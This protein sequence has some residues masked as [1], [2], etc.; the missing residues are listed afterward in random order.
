[1]TP[2][3]RL[4]PFVGAGKLNGPKGARSRLRRRRRDEAEGDTKRNSVRPEEDREAAD[5]G[6][7]SKN[8]G[9]STAGNPPKNPSP[10]KKKPK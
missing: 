4:G 3:P 2:W 9:P 8:T 7:P 6:D 1:M 5:E 10:S